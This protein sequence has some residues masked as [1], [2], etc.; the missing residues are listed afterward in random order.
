MADAHAKTRKVVIDAGLD[1]FCRGDIGIAAGLVAAFEPGKPAPI[2]RTCQL[3]IYPH[4]LIE[5]A[6][7]SAGLSHLQVDQST[8]VIG[9]GVI[10][11]RLKHLVAVLKCGLQRAED[12]PRPAAPTPRGFQTGLKANGLVVVPRRAIILVLFQIDPGTVDES[13]AVFRIQLDSL[14]ERFESE[15]VFALPQVSRAA[16]AEGLGVSWIQLDRLIE[17]RNGAVKV[18]VCG[19]GIAAIVIGNSQGRRALAGSDEGRATIDPG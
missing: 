4:R 17:I 12:G 6:D 9:G 1:G 14:I 15:I 3:R 13:S 16:V 8:R 10:R 2:E 19:I 18:S 7:R 5:I 11:P